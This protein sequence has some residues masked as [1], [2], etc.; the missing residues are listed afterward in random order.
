MTA[1]YSIIFICLTGCSLG[2]RVAD[3]PDAAPPID[4]APDAPPNPD[5]PTPFVDILPAGSVVPSLST[6]AE[7]LL[8][9]RINDGLVDA[10]LV[11][12][13]G[14]VTRGTGK[15]A[16]A[17]VRFWNFGVAPTESGITVAAPLYVFGRITSGVFT[18]LSTHLPMI[19]T[20]PGDT[21]YSPIRRVINVPVTDLYAGELITSL[22]ALGEAIERGLVSDPVP[23]GTWMNMPV[24][25]P[26][27]KLEVAA[28]PAAPLPAKQV[29]GRGYLVDVFELGTSLGRQPLRSGFI[30]VAQA[31]TLLDGVATPGNPPT[32]TTTVH[33]QPVFQ[34]PIPT[35]VMPTVF[36]YSPVSTDVVVR[37]ADGVAPSA[38][39]SDLDL[40]RRTATGVMTAYVPSNVASFTVGTLV[41]NLQIQYMEGS[42]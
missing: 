28:A 38:I 26:G 20:V 19:D 40:F 17:T 15:A 6:N 1:T 23:D 29:Y 22:P 16:G 25:L 31:S 35:V 12:S 21:R 8:Q 37:L 32:L 9:I 3:P 42:P 18:P 33:A 27:T 7:L 24:V 14:V 10:A 5:G 36:S 41:Q 2:P 34:Y 11:A 30:P 13:G 4:A 39:T